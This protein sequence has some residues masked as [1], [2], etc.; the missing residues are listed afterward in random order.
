MSDPTLYDTMQPTDGSL[1]LAH[2]QGIR[3][4]VDGAFVNITGDVNNLN[5][6][7]SAITVPREVYGLKGRTSSQIIGYNFAPT[8]TV[9]AVRD[10][11]GHVA[12]AWLVD[13]LAKAYSEGD[14]NL[15]EFQLFDLKDENLPAFQG[16]FSIAVAPAA[17]GFAEK[18]GYAFTLA[19]DGVVSQITSPVASDGKPIIESIPTAAGKTTGDQ[20]VLKGYHFSGTT[21][22]TIDAQAATEFVVVDDYTLVFVIPADVSGTAAV[23]VTNAA[24]AGDPVDYSAA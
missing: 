23:V 22:V 12:Q 17:T 6:N 5:A 13:L 4:K 16:K 8:F 9:E 11:T 1:A 3:Y 7:P 15:G 18:G 2:E 19:N 10:T 14:A 21:G 20:V 24:G